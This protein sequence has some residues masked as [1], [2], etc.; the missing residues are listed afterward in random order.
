MNKDRIKFVDWVIL[1]CLCELSPF[2]FSVLVLLV[3]LVIFIG[4]IA[5]TFRLFWSWIKG[6]WVQ[7][8]TKIAHDGF[9]SLEVKSIN[10]PI[11][12][13]IMSTLPTKKPPFIYLLFHFLPASSFTRFHSHIKHVTHIE[14]N[15]VCSFS[16]DYFYAQYF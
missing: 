7:R 11:G 2:F 15:T 9:I 3:K 4:L 12:F 16:I 10:F 6:G 13:I 1:V 5:R 14:S 8:E